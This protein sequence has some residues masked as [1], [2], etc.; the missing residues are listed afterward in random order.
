M[1]TIKTVAP[2]RHEVYSVTG[3]GDRHPVLIGTGLTRT[4]ALKIIAAQH[5]QEASAWAA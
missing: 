2:N 5:M 3:P 4:D 1:F